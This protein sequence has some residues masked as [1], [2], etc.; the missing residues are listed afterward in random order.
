LTPTPQPHKKPAGFSKIDQL[1]RTRAF[2][3][4]SL[5]EQAQDAFKPEPFKEVVKQSIFA[6]IT[7]N[8]RSLI[9]PHR[10]IVVPWSELQGIAPAIIT[11]T[12]YSSLP[13]HLAS[14]DGT[15]KNN[16]SSGIAVALLPQQDGLMIVFAILPE[17]SSDITEILA[18]NLAMENTNF[19]EA[20]KPLH[21]LT[22]YRSTVTKDF[23]RG[24]VSDWSNSS[25]PELWARMKRNLD[26]NP[27]TTSQ[28]V[29]AHQ[30]RT[31]AIHKINMLGTW[32]LMADEAA[33]AIKQ[34]VDADYLA[35]SLHPELTLPPPDK[36]SLID[37]LEED[38][39]IDE[40]NT[41]LAQHLSNTP[42][43]DGNRIR[44]LRFLDPE[45]RLLLL[46]LLNEVWRGSPLP[47]RDK[48]SKLTLIFKSG[49]PNKY[50]NWR[51]VS[52][53]TAFTALLSK[54]VN[55][56]FLK[57]LLSC[58]LLSKAQR[59][60][61]RGHYGV[62]DNISFLLTAL[63]EHFHEATKNK[64]ASFNLLLADISKAFDKIHLPVIIKTLDNLVGTGK[65]LKLKGLIRNMYTGAH[66]L[67][68]DED[69]NHKLIQKLS[70]VLQ[71]DALSGTLFVL[72]AN[73]V[74]IT[75][76]PDQAAPAYTLEYATH[77]AMLHHLFI[78]DLFTKTRETA[79]LQSATDE[80]VG[81]LQTAL[82][83]FN[84]TK[85]VH[86]QMGPQTPPV[87]V[88][89]IPVRKASQNDVFTGLG[90][91]LR[92]SDRGYARPTVLDTVAQ[93]QAMINRLKDSLNSLT[94][95][96]EHATH[97]DSPTG[98][99][100]APLNT[101]HKNNPADHGRLREKRRPT[102]ERHPQ[103]PHYPPNGPTPSRWIRPHSPRRHRRHLSAYATC[104]QHDLS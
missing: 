98:E 47:H 3:L 18:T 44:H 9:S 78:D 63:A 76:N 80:A 69:G 67:M 6:Q 54:I 27:S 87:T 38:L 17:A 7:G 25:C 72:V 62:R 91:K 19:T 1:H 4:N 83:H 22:D 61:I 12:D 59:G 50:Q 94:P 29:K 81:N 34:I 65:A 92:A 41:A 15:G 11:Q 96:V 71:G 60:C 77:H 93:H 20:Q 82:L 26:Q 51:P 84:P 102:L 100:Q 14:T 70:G 104:L 28:H 64:S 68:S 53:Q 95:K 35:A 86:L 48:M 37:A 85:T 55:T 39:N 99:R 57:V 24:H 10:S 58:S 32:N 40:L 79:D 23:S 66:T 90:V 97:Q 30:D 33:N 8:E 21:I 75:L 5:P 13:V 56:R 103:P 89:D 74:P 43:P 2:K 36:E 42:G 46:D 49:N 52:V 45:N 31:T 73:L 88:D 101:I 16:G